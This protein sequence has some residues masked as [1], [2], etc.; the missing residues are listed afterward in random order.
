MATAVI[1]NPNPNQNETQPPINKNLIDT[2]APK[3]VSINNLNIPSN[4]SSIDDKTKKKI[5]NMLIIYIKTRMAN[6]YKINYDPRTNSC[7]FR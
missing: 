2:N 5:P 4:T 7:K 1:N 6:Y 3:N